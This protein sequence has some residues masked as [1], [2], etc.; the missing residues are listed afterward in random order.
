MFALTANTDGPCNLFLMLWP[1]ENL[2]ICNLSARY[3]KECL[4]YGFETCSADRE[5]HE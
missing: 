1:F 5:R 4:R 2:D 3:F